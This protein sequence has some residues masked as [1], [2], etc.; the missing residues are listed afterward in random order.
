LAQVKILQ[1]GDAPIAGNVTPPQAPAAQVPMAPVAKPA[2]NTATVVDA[3]GRRI[4]VRKLF[5]L[6]KLR[7]FA[8]A[9]ELAKN[10]SWMSLAAISWAI[11]SIDG[12]NMQPNSI[13]EIEATLSTLGDEGVE[14]AAIA[15]VSLMPPGDAAEDVQ[16]TAKN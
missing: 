13:R 15:Y 7:L 4:T 2:S 10:E 14:A 6:Q 9:G 8:V 5:P 1:A 11:S 16:A 3:T 12:E